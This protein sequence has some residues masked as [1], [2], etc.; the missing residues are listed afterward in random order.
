[1]A[2]DTTNRITASLGPKLVRVR[3]LGLSSIAS[4]VGALV[5]SVACTSFANANVSVGRALSAS[6]LAN[7]AVTGTLRTDRQLAGAAAATS[8]CGAD[9]TVV[10]GLAAVVSTTGVAT[11]T[12]STAGGMDAVARSTSVAAGTITVARL[13]AA[14]V[15]AISA[16]AGTFGTAINLSA[17]SSIASVALG[18]ITVARSLAATAPSAGFA[19]GTL[20][21]AKGFDAAVFGVLTTSADLT[22]ARQIAATVSAVSIAVA[23][24]SVT[25]ALA[26]AILATSNATG[27]LSAPASAGLTATQLQSGRVY[28][29]STT[30]GGAAGKGA[31][32]IAVPITLTA[33]ASAIDY[34]LRDADATSTTVQDWT[35]AGTN[36]PAN[37]TS[38]TCS[39]VPAKAQRYLLDLRANGDSAQI[40]LGTSPVMMGRIIAGAGQ[41]QIAAAFVQNTSSGTN[42][43]LGVTISPYGAVY[44]RVDTLT[45]RWAAPADGGAYPSTFA[46]EFLRRQVVTSGVA[47]AWVGCAVGQTPISAWA[48]GTTNNVNLRAVL[49]AV[50]GFEAFYW[51]QGG[52]DAGGGT[53]KA[54]YKTSLDA[55]FADITAHNAIFGGTYTKVLTATATRLAAGAGSTIQVTAI[56][57]AH[58]EW[59]AANGGIYLEP[60]DVNLGDNVHQN[61]PGN[62]VLAQHVHRALRPSL[63]LTGGDVGATLGT[64]TIAAG[65]SVFKIPV[66][67]PTGASSLVLTGNAYTRFSVF[68]TGTLANGLTPTAVAY[69]TST[70]PPTL[71]LTVSAAPA[72]GVYDLYAFLHP[73]PSGTTAFSDMIRDDHVDGDGITLGRSLE[74][75]TSGP[76]VATASAAAAQAPGQ[77]TA[78][79][80]GTA[81]ASSQPL[82]WSAPSTGGAPTAYTAEYRKSSDTA[83]TTFASNITGTTATITGLAASTSYDYRV[84]ATNASG[85]GAPSAT[86]SSTTIAAVVI[87]GPAVGEI[88]LVNLY[89]GSGSVAIPGWNN[90]NNA[91]YSNI[92]SPP[93]SLA[94]TNS[95][96]ASTGITAQ[97][98]NGTFAGGQNP[99]GKQTGNNSGVFPD[100]VM[101]TS[102]YADKSAST[103]IDV[104][105]SG[106]SAGT[107]WKVESLS[108]RDVASR[109]VNLGATGKLAQTINCGGN[110]STLAIFNDVAPEGGEIH[111]TATQ[112]GTETFTY[113]TAFRMTRTA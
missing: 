11:G 73:D 105:L 25:R 2:D 9:L 53:S 8:S 71:D 4:I 15:A 108:N 36:V 59:C 68:P 40:V 56:R 33:A 58:K 48:P 20:T 106:V 85:S 42:A 78:L 86:A 97:I 22:V 44:A 79:T 13:L 111:V 26:A 65:A 90:L 82:S 77:V 12:L 31:G 10:K 94:I 23:D 34:R 27:T 92:A 46:S 47:C 61:Q 41:S 103:L 30:T 62:I 64:P 49:D 21:V 66:T 72:A 93:A 101:A 98:T 52:D 55:L 57:Q 6:V 60:H 39:G 32:S 14:S 76:V 24:L 109:L 38:I 29:R 50:G 1:M 83:W 104:K 87:S 88:I 19:T 3:V 91:V 75:S 43:S 7:V 45:E 16:A 51:Y 67:L 70:S 102:T 100:A 80:P 69:N 99:V 95:N 110:T 17:S 107:T 28:Q 112:N 63:G 84:T 35:S 113:L 37:T 74:P 81:T 54:S 96:G 89:Y 5:A 18:D